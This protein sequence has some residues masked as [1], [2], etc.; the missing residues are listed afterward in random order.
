VE[1]I[2]KSSISK[3]PRT[4]NTKA[5]KSPEKP[6]KIE[7]SPSQKKKIDSSVS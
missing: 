1:E 6:E 5:T 7:K 4:K 2:R 3:S